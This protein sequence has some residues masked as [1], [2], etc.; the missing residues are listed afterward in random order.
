MSTN[1]ATI[2]DDSF[3]FKGSITR[4]QFSLVQR[5]LLPWWGTT[6]VS[7]L[8]MVI[9]TLVIG[10][11]DCLVNG[12]S[13]LEAFFSLA[14]TPVLIVFTAG[15]TAWGRQLQWRQ[16]SANAQEITGNLGD[17][18]IEWNTP[19]TS[20]KF[21][22]SKLVKVRQ[23]REMLL[24]FYNSRCAFYVPRNFFADEATWQAANALALERLPPK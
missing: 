17:A 14:W 16:V 13:P 12:T 20:A 7:M 22:W 1:T 11:Q 24:I 10:V 2:Q 4:E 23:H 5:L 9:G 15:L 19:M 18:G 6:R 3:P 8:W 21:P